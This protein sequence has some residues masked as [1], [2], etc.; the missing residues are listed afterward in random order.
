[1]SLVIERF[2]ICNGD[3]C[4]SSTGDGNRHHPNAFI[5]RLEAKKDG[6]HVGLIKD[7]CPECYNKLKKEMGNKGKDEEKAPN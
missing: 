1:M 2:L 3:N 6:W 4:E 5:L 7:L